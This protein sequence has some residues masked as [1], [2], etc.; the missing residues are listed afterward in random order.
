MVASA[1]APGEPSQAK[2]EAAVKQERQVAKRI[3]EL[4]R[5]SG[6]AQ[7][8]L[9]KV[10]ADDKG[11]THCK[12]ARTQAQEHFQS[13]ERTGPRVQSFGMKFASLLWVARNPR[14]RGGR[15]L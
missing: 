12:R 8:K 7:K 6:V 4:E 10:E 2:G 15:L 13:P 14:C 5:K 1:A 9:S 3:E 11:K